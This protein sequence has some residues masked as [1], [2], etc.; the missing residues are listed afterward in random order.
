MGDSILIIIHI[1]CVSAL[2]VSAY[3]TGFKVC[4]EESQRWAEANVA[5][6]TEI[7]ER[8]NMDIK[9]FNDDEKDR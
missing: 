6:L 9:T 5:P 4:Q 7:L 3:R 1:V 2:Y 8:L